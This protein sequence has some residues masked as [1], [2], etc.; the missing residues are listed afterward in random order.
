M[1]SWALALLAAS[2]AARAAVPERKKRRLVI[3]DVPD[4]LDRFNTQAV[5]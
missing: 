4:I 3:M 1:T 2:D 5:A